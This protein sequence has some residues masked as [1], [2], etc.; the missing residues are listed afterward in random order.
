M[1]CGNHT[2]EQVCHSGPCGECPRSGKRPCPCEKSSKDFFS[3]I[4][5]HLF[6]VIGFKHSPTSM[7]LQENVVAQ[8]YKCFLRSDGQLLTSAVQLL[9]RF[10]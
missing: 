8:V 4:E 3:L 10:Q 2:C 7:N 6:A 9:S 1:P 5:A